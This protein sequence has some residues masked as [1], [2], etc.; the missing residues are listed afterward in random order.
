MISTTKTGVKKIGARLF[1][2]LLLCL[3]SIPSLLTAAVAAP[4]EQAQINITF[5]T[6]AYWY[7]PDGKAGLFVTLENKSQQT[8][9]DVSIRLRL[10]SPNSSRTDLDAVLEGKPRRSYRHTETLKRGIS[11]KRGRSSFKFNI[12]LADVRL[13][14]GV[15]PITVETLRSGSVVDSATSELVVMSDQNPQSTVPLKLSI[16]FDMLEP[17]HRAPD[18]DFSDNGLAAECYPGGRSPGWYTSISD[19]MD[20]H[21]NL[22][23]TFSF[24]PL[25]VEEMQDMT[26]GYVVR[27]GK[28]LERF[29]A[30][31]TEANNAESTLSTYK[32]MAQD[33]RFQFLA[34]PYA[35]PD[36]EKLVA[37]NWSDDARGQISRGTRD[38]EAA[39]GIKPGQGYFY[40]PGLNCNS[41]VIKMLAGELGHFLILNPGLLERN[42]EGRKLVKGLTLSTPVEIAGAKEGQVLALFAD[43]R[44]E[45]LVRR[46]ARNGDER[47][48]AQAL[49]SELTNLYLE[50]PAKLRACAFVWPSWWRPSRRVV[51]E[52]MKALSGA[53][54]LQSVTLGE[55]LS[56]VPPIKDFALF[57]PASGRPMDAYFKE[58]N[59]ARDKYIG[60][61]NTV[62]HG[63]PVMPQLLQNLYISESDVW[64]QWGRQES[65]LG[66][67]RAVS[68]TVDSELAKVKIPTM[69]SITLT[70][71]DANIPLP[72]TNETGYRVKVTLQF[73]GSGLT[74]PKGQT[75]KVILE[76]KE[77]MLEIPVN[78]TKKGRVRFFARIV[79][80]GT[81]LAKTEMSVL[82]SRFNVFA[83]AV[84]CGILVLI[85][86]GWGIR[87]LSRRRVGKHKQGN[88]R[89]Q[90]EEGTEA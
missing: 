19:E 21:E 37:Y 53:P 12:D 15:F 47:Y 55:N 57:I 30:N 4:A 29:G 81:V 8:L 70:S 40:P 10:H 6:D 42:R 49:L 14:N 34:T 90:E 67:A 11:L 72:V 13:W 63:N 52:V 64:R 68:D 58:V 86:A 56:T 62:L 80:D 54:W 69:S 59:K 77:N 1:C 50:R 43:G 27:Q 39:F 60:F 48:V 3:L 46:L 36:L 45:V 76:P 33:L 74:F 41:R 22:H 28:S 35:S 38:L 16:I 17:P 9:E 88:I 66:F 82:T 61:T 20:K 44:V 85:I 23:T 5:Y 31:S 75:Q 24:S 79:A 73:D 51:Q 65:G 26:D 83:I 18:G 71:T 87:I 84:V 32:K 25:V 2:A 78:V 89:K 7:K